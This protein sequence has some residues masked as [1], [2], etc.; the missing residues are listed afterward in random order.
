MQPATDVQHLVIRNPLALCYI[1]YTCGGE[2][3]PNFTV[4]GRLNVKKGPGTTGAAGC[5]CEQWDK[6]LPPPPPNNN[7]NLN[8]QADQTK[9]MALGTSRITW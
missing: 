9:D 6:C 4:W 5:N 1:S 7:N 2:H 3:P 8:Q